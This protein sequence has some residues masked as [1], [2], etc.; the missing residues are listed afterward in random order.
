MR[1]RAAHAVVTPGVT[2]A[3]S[4]Q[5][6]IKEALLSPV[7][8]TQTSDAPAPASVDAVEPV[9][10]PVRDTEAMSPNGEPETTTSPATSRQSRTPRASRPAAGA[11]RSRVAPAEAP[12]TFPRADRPAPVPAPEHHHLPGWVRRDYARVRPALADL[13]ALLDGSARDELQSRIDELTAGISS[14]RFS[15]AWRYPDVVEQ[16]RRLY[17]LQRAEHAE[18]AQASRALDTARRRATARLRDAADMLSSEASSR[19]Q[20]TVR[21]APDLAAIAAAEAELERTVGNARTAHTRR[22]DKE[23]ERTKARIRRSTPRPAVVE[24]PAAETWQDVLRRFAEQQDE[25]AS[26]SAAG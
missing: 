21:S 7:T 18:R 12:R 1:L 14:G 13:L 9:T 3:V 15:L 23:I 20:R 2:A 5:L 25:D 8:A 19:L 10:D 11:R 6:S 22:R 17:E 16:G 24:Q 26:G 4:R